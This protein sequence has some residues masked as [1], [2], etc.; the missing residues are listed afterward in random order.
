MVNYTKEDLNKNIK[1]KEKQKNLRKDKK[2]NEE[3]IFDKDWEFVLNYLEFLY[4]SRFVLV[5]I[6]YL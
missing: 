3:N 4:F 2:Q 5:Y 6:F 1:E